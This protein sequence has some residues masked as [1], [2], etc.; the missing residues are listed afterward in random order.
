M[1]QI[2]F[3]SSPGERF[4]DM[5]YEPYYHPQW[6]KV[7]SLP[8]MVESFKAVRATKVA[9]PTRL[10]YNIIAGF[11]DQYIWFHRDP[12]D[13]HEWDVHYFRMTEGRHS[14]QKICDIIKQDF[15]TVKKK[16]G[17]TEATKLQMGIVGNGDPAEILKQRHNDWVQDVQTPTGYFIYPGDAPGEQDEHW[18]DVDYWLVDRPHNKV[19][20]YGYWARTIG[21]GNWWTSPDDSE[22]ALMYNNSGAADPHFTDQ[23]GEGFAK[24]STYDFPVYV[25]G[26][27]FY[28]QFFTKCAIFLD[29]VDGVTDFSWNAKINED[30]PTPLIVFDMVPDN[31]DPSADLQTIKF[32]DTTPFRRLAQTANVSTFLIRWEFYTPVLDLWWTPQQPLTPYPDDP[33]WWYK[34]FSPYDWTLHCEVT[35]LVDT[36]VEASIIDNYM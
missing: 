15:N 28:K 8:D 2:V 36:D 1:K 34:W 19:D 3:D 20:P 13:P 4:P 23:Y 33:N 32:P 26:G 14:Q 5:L 18:N 25:Q 12:A 24:D 31:W 10:F 29:T 35:S 17:A 6:E 7:V 27:P 11:N 22:M 30:R 21:M 16:A 9:I